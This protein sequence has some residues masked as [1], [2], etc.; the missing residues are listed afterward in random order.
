[1]TTIIYGQSIAVNARARRHARRRAAALERDSLEKIV[2]ADVSVRPVVDAPATSH[3]LSRIDKAVNS[4]SL[5]ERNKSGTVCLPAVAL[6][7]G[8][9]RK[10]Y[11]RKE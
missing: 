6:Y 9:R 1:M 8:G 10:H 5:R 3:H 7:A 2:D 4:P 11:K